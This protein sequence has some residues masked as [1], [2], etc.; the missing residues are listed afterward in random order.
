MI[1]TKIDWDYAPEWANYAAMDNTGIWYWYE[2][3][4]HISHRWWNL[5]VGRFEKIM[6]EKDF[7][8]SLQKRT[9]K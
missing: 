6:Q 8:D 9:L 4:P 7:S 1:I 5:E 3:E 2:F